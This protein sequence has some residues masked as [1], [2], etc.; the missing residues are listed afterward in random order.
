MAVL[1]PKSSST[2]TIRVVMFNIISEYLTFAE[3]TLSGCLQHR[4][5]SYNVYEVRFSL[6]EIGSIPVRRLVIR[7][8]VVVQLFS[9]VYK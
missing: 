6:C 9:N 5:R 1:L 8:D 7:I 4:A 2:P 3:L